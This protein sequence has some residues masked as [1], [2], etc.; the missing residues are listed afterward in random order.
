MS[1]YFCLEPPPYTARCYGRGEVPSM[2]EME[3]FRNTE[4]FLTRNIFVNFAWL[5]CT[6]DAVALRTHVREYD[7]GRDIL[8]EVQHHDCALE[9]GRGR[10][11]S[12]PQHRCDTRLTT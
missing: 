5:G 9:H 7:C 1:K 8:H 10:G 6:R 11:G 4:Y 2:H 3:S 12:R